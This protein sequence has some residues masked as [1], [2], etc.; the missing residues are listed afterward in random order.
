MFD[1]VAQRREHEAALAAL[2]TNRPTS[3]HSWV[4]EPT[5]NHL[6]AD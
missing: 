2:L 6:L 4:D 5:V 1:K 3:H